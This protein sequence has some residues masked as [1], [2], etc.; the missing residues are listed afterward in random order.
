MHVIDMHTHIFPPELIAARE[1]LRERDRWFGLLYANPRARLASAEDLLASMESAGVAASVAFG[2][3]FLDQGLCRLCN[4]YVLDAAQRHPGRILPLAVANPL[5]GARALADVREALDAGAIGIGELM[6]DGQGFHLEETCLL[7][8][9]MELA[10]AAGALVMLHVNE[11]VGHGYAGKGCQGPQE[12]YALAQRYP[13]NVL[14]LAHWGGG[15]P[16]YEL[17]PEGRVAL[18]NVYY[19]TAASLYLYDAAVFRHVHAWAPNKVLLGSDYPLIRQKRFVEHVYSAGLDAEGLQ[20][21]LGG[22]ALA[23]L[24]GLSAVRRLPQEEG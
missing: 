9:L 1:H 11:Q 15:L 12:A 21:V 19:D 18:H 6:P 22:N 7:D 2:F 8:P 5:A 20:R 14:V 16:F 10:R 17:M 3:A 23:L 13:E 24:G 4:D